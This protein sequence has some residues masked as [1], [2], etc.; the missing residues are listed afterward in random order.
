MDEESN[1]ELSIVTTLYHSR[2][3]LEEYLKE[4]I[5]E[6]NKSK[7][8]NFE[9]LF[10]N[11]GSPDDSLEFL[12]ILKKNIPEI[13]IIDLSRNFGH[14]FAIQEGL[15]QAKGELVFL[16]DNDLETPGSV[17]SEFIEIMRKEKDLD[18]VF[19]F[20]EN[21]KGN[22]F[23]RITGGLFWKIFNIL[24]DTKIPN[25]IVTER[26]MKRKYIIELMRLGDANLFIGG[27]FHWVGFNQ[28][29]VSLKRGQRKG[30]STYTRKKKMDLMIHAITSFSG[31][32]LEWLFYFGLTI[33][34][35]SLVVIFILIFNKILY[36]NEVQ[37]GW[38]TL[39]AVNIFILGILSTFLGVIG[40]YVNKI[41]RQVQNR[42]NVI[43]RKI[44]D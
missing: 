36:A 13:K 3:F 37:I 38:T 26:L 21:R 2:P 9:L 16:I 25:N 6:V 22:F 44:Y 29:G 23:E 32:P 42:P 24:S 28:K 15:A 11:D 27:M 7:V 17:I 4:V 5:F 43:I 12:L 39:V 14:H 1:L 35:L 18:V 20:Q 40:I 41:F 33:S 31:K 8:N 30:K 34:F 10:V 19:G